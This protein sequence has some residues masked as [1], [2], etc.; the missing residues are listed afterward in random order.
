MLALNAIPEQLAAALIAAGYGKKNVPADDP[1]LGV[2]TYLVQEAGIIDSGTLSQWLTG[3]RRPSIESLKRICDQIG[4]DVE[5]IIKPRARTEQETTNTRGEIMFQAYT[6]TPC[7][8]TP[9]EFQ[10]SPDGSDEYPDVESLLEDC[11][12][13][14]ADAIYE[15]GEDELPEEIKDIR[16]KIHNQRGRIFGFFDSDRPHYFAVIGD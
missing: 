10:I 13:C 5:V 9:S 15:L 3:K 4:A 12:W 6:I 14:G 2:S 16:G 7:D 1:C 8:S 11:H